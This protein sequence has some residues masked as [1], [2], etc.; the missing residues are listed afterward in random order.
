MGS[1][2]PVGKSGLVPRPGTYGATI[3]DACRCSSSPPAGDS[4]ESGSL[5]NGMILAGIPLR[6][7][8][9]SQLRLGACPVASDR[10]SE[11]RER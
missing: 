3:A 2:W 11:T 1:S 6:A 5:E 9:V 4:T 10:A 8:G 7:G